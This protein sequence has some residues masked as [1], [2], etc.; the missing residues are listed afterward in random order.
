MLEASAKGPWHEADDAAQGPA[1]LPSS[2][3]RPRRPRRSPS[4]IDPDRP[5]MGDWTTGTYTPLWRGLQVGKTGRPFAPCCS[6]RRGDGLCQPTTG[7]ANATCG[8]TSAHCDDCG[9][10]W[11]DR[12]AREPV[13]PA[14]RGVSGR[15]P[16]PS[17]RSLAASG[18]ECPVHVALGSHPGA[19]RRLRNWS[20]AAKSHP[21][22]C[23]RRTKTAP[24]LAAH[25]DLARGSAC[26]AMDGTAGAFSAATLALRAC[27]GEEL[28]E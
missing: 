20:F 14:A 17:E 8:A 1:E 21:R 12:S 11:S 27:P 3:S 16:Q 15:S 18:R 9:G 7:C 28:G 13:P 19:G 2:C 26:W 23:A 4:R 24:D 10:Y 6:G 22:H 5:L 25:T